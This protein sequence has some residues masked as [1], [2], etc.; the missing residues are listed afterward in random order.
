ME[1]Y[2]GASVEWWNDSK[3]GLV[4]LR[5]DPQTSRFALFANDTGMPIA[6]CAGAMGRKVDFIT[7]GVINGNWTGVIITA[8]N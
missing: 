2:R 4:A 6:V 5:I 8:V 1:S 3:P 7:N